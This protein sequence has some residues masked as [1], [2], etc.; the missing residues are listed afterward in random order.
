MIFHIEQYAQLATDSSV[1]KTLDSLI[2]NGIDTFIVR[3][4]V[5][6]KEKVMEL[7]PVQSEVMTMNSVTL[8]DTWIKELIDESGKYQSVR[9]MMEKNLLNPREKRHTGAAPEWAIGSVHAVT[10]DGKVVVASATWSQLPAYVY[11]ATHVL[12]VVGIQK[13]VKNLDDAMLRIHEY[14][15]PLENERAMRAYGIGSSE[16]KILIFNKEVKPGR[17]SM[18]LVKEQLWF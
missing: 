11:G 14:V 17:I 10:E 12:W 2:Q 7:I 3:D 8:K 16:N 13:I 9:G 1:Q 5:Q 6:A 18:I 15:L 4:R